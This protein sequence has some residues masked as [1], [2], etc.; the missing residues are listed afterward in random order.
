MEATMAVQQI[1][2][3]DLKEK[4]NQ[5]KLTIVDFHADWCGPCK[6]LAP[7]LDEVSN[8][9][10]GD[11]EIFKVDVDSEEYKD[12]TAQYMIMSIPTV[13]F[14]KEGKMIHH[15]IGLYDKEAILEMIEAH[16]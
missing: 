7:V 2:L 16:K 11:F 5:T 13:L 12:F 1:A 8:Q 4:I 9:A 10:G 6:Q 3:N 15:F 14:F